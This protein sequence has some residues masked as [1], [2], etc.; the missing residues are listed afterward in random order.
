M[1]MK[2][3][4]V[5]VLVATSLL[6]CATCTGLLIPDVFT[7]YPCGGSYCNLCKTCKCESCKVGPVPNDPVVNAALH[8][9]KRKTSCGVITETYA[10]FKQHI[11]GCFTCLKISVRTMHEQITK[12]NEDLQNAEKTRQDVIKTFHL[13]IASLASLNTEQTELINTLKRKF[14][15]MTTDNEIREASVIKNTKRQTDLVKTLKRKCEVLNGE[16]THLVQMN[17]KQMNLITKKD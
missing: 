11:G 2:S 15:C 3:L 12:K 17:M 9:C 10:L 1:F 4:N 16:K 7:T 8:G 14:V 5:N 13:K 6:S